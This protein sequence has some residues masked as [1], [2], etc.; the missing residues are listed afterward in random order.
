M[1]NTSIKIVILVVSLLIAVGAI[2]AFW[3]LFVEPPHDFEGANLHASSLKEDIGKITSSKDRAYNDSLYI[4]IIDKYVVFHENGHISDAENDEGL[5]NF[6]RIFIATYSDLCEK[7]FNSARWGEKGFKEITQRINSLKSL[8]LSNGNKVVQGTDAGKLND[9]E[10]VID[11]YK[12]A[13]KAASVS[14]YQSVSQAKSAINN[15]STYAS[16]PYISKSD[17]QDKLVNVKKVI[18]KSH[19]AFLEDKV[20][21]LRSYR[22][23]TK[24]TFES[25]CA[26]IKTELQNYEGVKS[27]YGSSAKDISS[28]KNTLGN[29]WTEAQRYY[30]SLIQPAIT[31]SIGG[32]TTMTSPSTSYKAFMSQSYRGVPN[33]TCMMS[34][35][36]KGYTTF[37]FYIRSYAEGEYD[38]VMVGQLNQRP[39]SNNSSSIYASTK[40]NQSSGTSVY[41]YR[42]VTYSGLQRTQEY[43]IYVVYRKDGSNNNNDDRGYLLLPNIATATY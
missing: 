16:D 12:N 39:D 1:K 37:T 13:K 8:K 18:G 21:A 42:T 6:S 7:K 11:R 3:K 5:K 28:L 40:G 35:R 22:S 26:D 17:L 36:I 29:L 20:D 43:T 41:N 24:E 38:Y 19:Y 9:I 14:T 27:I 30:E 31:Y 15:A 32:W 25:K 2:L 23:M 10:G 33:S 34:F 4:V